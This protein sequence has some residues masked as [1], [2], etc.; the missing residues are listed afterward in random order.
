[1]C[2]HGTPYSDDTNVPLMIQGSKWIKPGRYGQYAET[3][4]IAPTLA[5]ILN[6]RVPSASEGKVLPHALISK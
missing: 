5:Q 3:V 4:H 1:M 6:I 2:S